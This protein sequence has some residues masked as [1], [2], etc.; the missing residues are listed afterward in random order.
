MSKIIKEVICIVGQ[1]ND[2]HGNQKNRY[3]RI[4]SIIDT[5]KGDMLKLDCI[6]IKE[7]GWNG[8]AYLSEPKERESKPSG[9]SNYGGAPG[10]SKENKENKE[11]APPYP[12]MSDED[13][14]F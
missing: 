9:N 1:Y 6:P 12:P 3:Q 2:M 4:G 10:F 14:P 5:Q 8:W 13:L 7:G 11:N